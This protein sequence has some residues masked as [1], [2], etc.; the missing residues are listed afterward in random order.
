VKEGSRP[1]TRLGALAST[2]GRAAGIAAMVLSSV[3]FT[4][5]SVLIGYAKGVSSFLTS[6]AR[7]GVG[8]VVV[9]TLALA[10]RVRLD[11]RNTKLLLL[12]G[13]LG[14]VAVFIYFLSIPMLGVARG[15]V[16]NNSYPLFAA[17]G[18]ALFLRERVSA[19]GWVAVAL[20]LAGLGLLRLGDWLASPAWDPWFVVALAGS[21]LSGLAVVTVRKLTE[22]DSSPVIFLSQ[23]VLGFWLVFVPALGSP[24]RLAV[25][26]AVL[27]LAI[28][29]TAAV[30]QLLMTWSYRSVDVTTGSLISVLTPVLSVVFG[31]LLFREALGLLQAAGMALI[32]AAC[33][34]IVVPWRA[35]SP[36]R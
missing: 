13:L 21:L 16:I 20:T 9:C 25:P 34:L 19:A 1:S 15:T 14:G 17:V 27:L 35:R 6:F 26:M 10:G 2:G 8:A 31:V 33:V 22:T 11:F 7:F 28:G 18:G 3:L 32:L 29:L 30:A 24:S 4:L 23:S 36:E 12:R 5:M